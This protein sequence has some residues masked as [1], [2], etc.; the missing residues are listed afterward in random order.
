MLIIFSFLAA[1]ILLGAMGEPP[2]LGGAVG[3]LLAWV[4]HLSQ[5]VQR[6]EQAQR[7]AAPVAQAVA[8]PAPV[9]VVKPASP[10]PP[11]AE[12]E[13]KPLPPAI[14]PAPVY[15]PPESNVLDKA[16]ASA[17]GWFTGG[18]PFVRVG[19]I[20]LFIGVVFLLRYSLEKGLL[21]V[22]LRL[23]GA[24]TGAFALLGYGWKLRHRTGA[25]GLILQAGGVGLLYLT[26]FAAFSLYNLL[27]ALPAFSLLLLTVIAATVLAL[28]QD[29]LPLAAFAA[30]GGFLAPLLTSTGSN[31]AIGLFSF[32][33]LLNAGIVAVAWFKAWRP[34]NLL[35]FMFTFVIA[36]LWGWF[37]YQTE[38]F[39]T[40]EPFLVLFFLFYVAIAIL[41][42]TRSP[43][44][45]K[46]KVDSTL[47][48]GTPILGFLM[49]TALVHEFEYGIALSAAAIGV[50]YLLLCGGLRRYF[51]P[52]QPLLAETFLALGVVFLTLAVPLTVDGMKTAAA[53]AVEGVGILWVSIR[54]HQM[55][56]RLFAVVLQYASLLA[57]LS[58]AIPF[59]IQD[60][61]GKM[62][63]L[64]GEFLSVLLVS[65]AMLVSSRL[66]S[67][68]FNG[69]HG[70]EQ[71][72]ATTLFFTALLF[73]SLLFEKQIGDF[74]QHRY[75]TAL[76]LGY[77][78]LI[79]IGLMVMSRFGE[80][81]L[82]RYTLPLALLLITLA[83]LNT[84]GKN[85]SI[86]TGWDGLG[87]LSAFATL[88]LASFALQQRGWFDDLLHFTHTAL[89]WLGF[90]VLSHEL[91][92]QVQTLVNPGSTWDV[93]SMP[94]VGMAI[95]AWLIAG[96]HWPIPDYKTTLLH[97]VAFP[98]AGILGLWVLLSLRSNGVTPPIPWMPLLNP[99]DTVTLIIACLFWRLY[100]HPEIAQCPTNTQVLR[101]VGVGLVFLWAN[102]LILRA[103]HH[104]NGL[105]WEFPDLL[106][107]P[108]TQTLIAIAWTLG[109]MALAWQ[110]NR[111]GK[112]KLWVFG[113]ALL[114]AV[115]LK[116]FVV[117]FAASG[118]L[119]RIVSFLSVGVLLLFIGYLAPLP[120]AEQPQEP[121]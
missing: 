7:H 106:L 17:W 85:E 110:A 25:Y 93:A 86:V 15:Q 57:L 90:A 47:V 27:P 111:L 117:D 30:T 14:V 103:Q 108:S 22:E 102:T 35:G 61:S 97:Y 36:T 3:A 116:L 59:S 66:L 88:Y 12:T 105:A 73:L 50:F 60:V 56:R 10:Q 58:V 42:A 83:T 34:L 79:S 72:I 24:A 20:L 52:K 95:L 37:S 26:V 45:F 92:V 4:H 29:S 23:L 96:K 2:L 51:D 9:T 75:L 21:P 98:L 82:L 120:P 55:A 101:Y 1:A 114:G 48:F 65:A 94:L 113:A 8:P 84:L 13:P 121:S 38:N 32:Y 41:F 6:L 112:R 43:V 68:S 46:D 100:W 19:I 18:N 39:T 118:T 89:L 62:A 107:Q 80:W 87:W 69:K 104:W 31:N 109:G 16:F 99:L 67:G 91:S 70:F 40:T 28:K 33:A 5:R 115:V 44:N 49:Q 54:Q 78:T 64:N 74:S 119:A 77:A 11:T 63:F 53:W 71:T 76:H 81:P